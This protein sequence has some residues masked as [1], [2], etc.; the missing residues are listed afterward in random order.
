MLFVGTALFFLY[1][2]YKQIYPMVIRKIWIYKEIQYEKRRIKKK[3]SRI[4]TRI[5]S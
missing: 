4:D 2:I 1:N 3:N 5:L